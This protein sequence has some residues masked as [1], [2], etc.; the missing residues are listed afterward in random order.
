MKILLA[1]E[2][3]VRVGE[4]GEDAASESSRRNA[5]RDGDKPPREGAHA[6]AEGVGVTTLECS[7]SHTLTKYNQFEPYKYFW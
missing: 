1:F 3:S 6:V 7:E 2:H 4:A 5:R